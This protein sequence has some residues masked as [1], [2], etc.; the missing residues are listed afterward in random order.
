MLLM[1]FMDGDGCGEGTYISLFAALMRGEYD[2]QLQWPF[3]QKVKLMFLSQDHQQK[4][5]IIKTVQPDPTE[6][7]DSFWKPSLNCDVNIPFGFPKFAPISILHD[8]VYV[9]N[10]SII[11]KCVIEI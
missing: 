8:P 9:K 11:F 3:A 7:D 5:D 2:T 10:D 1:I 4:E 6:F